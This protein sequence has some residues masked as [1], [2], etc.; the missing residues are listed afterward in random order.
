MKL[1]TRDQKQAVYTNSQS[2]SAYLRVRKLFPLLAT[3]AIVLIAAGLSSCSGYTTAPSVSG[4]GGGGGNPGDPGAGVL[5]ASSMNVGFGSVA[6]GSTGMQSVTVTNTGTSPVSISAAAITGAAFT[7]VGGNPASSVPVGQSITVQIQFAPTTTGAVTGTLTVTSDASNTPLAISL[8][9][10]GMQTVLTISPASLNFSN[11]PVG[12]TSTQTVTLG[13][14]GNSDLKINLATLTGTGFGMSGLSLPKTITAGQNLS[15]S[16]QF[17]PTSTTGST[18][19]IVFTD[20]APGPPQTLTMTGS[21][22]ATGSSLGAN[23]GSFNFN[24]VAVS[25][26]SSQTFTLTNS[27]NATITINQIVTTGPGFSASGLTVGQTI[28][29]GATATLTGTFAPTTKGAASGNIAITSTATNSTLNIPLSGTGTQGTLTAT[30]GSIPFGS[31]PVGAS[32]SVPV[33]LSNTGTSAVSITGHS[34]TGTGFTLTGWA[35]PGS[36][37]PGQTTSFTV[38]FAPT[39]GIAAS[40]SV[41]ITSNAPG[42]PL[43][44]GLTGT[45]TTTQAQMTISPATLPFNNVNVGGS[46]AQNVTLTNTGNT[47]LNI[48][49]ASITGT[50]YTMNL[51]APK[52]IAAGA[53]SILTVTFTPTSAGSFSGSVSISSNAPGSPATI[54]LTGTGIQP[55]IAASPTSVAF[56][57]VVVG[58]GNSQP[59]TL[60]NNGNGTLKFTNI[61]VTG[62]GMTITGLTTATTIA[63]GGNLTFN[64]VF[65]PT[66]TTTINGTIKLTTNGT[67][68]PLTI[69]LGGAGVTATRILSASPTSLSFGTVSVNN[70]SQLLATLTNNGNSNVTVS[71]V[72][73]TGAG[74]SASGV[75]NGMMLTPGQSATLTVTFAPVTPGAVNGARVSIASNATGSPTIITLSGTGQAVSGRSVALNWNA[76]PT[77]GINGYNVFR[78]TTSGGYGT[79][80]L[81]SSPIS[82]LTFTDSS[83]SSG[84]TYF[85]VVM[86]VNSAGNSPP[87]NEVPV[88]IP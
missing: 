4:T 69:S 15:F 73:V 23:P 9:G 8:N 54:A 28:A 27:G 64:A 31:I 51:T 12:T 24:S 79:T 2:A 74:F 87:S 65:T 45:G 5:S 17:S 71:A 26:S 41:S 1:R 86:A 36:L 42:S 58:N 43:I 48:T 37:N 84:Q 16:V 22:V 63:A 32:A 38:T 72:T 55:Q 49:A 19:S 80:P 46:L 10:T 85:Y 60:R 52:T 82:G 44:I 53:T 88:S 81:N 78:A 14:S 62:A 47:A 6:V 21:A 66:S 61:T 33:T 13:N 59:I 11:I 7:V 70:S 75:S 76:S 18:G 30:P 35:A 3:F 68:S 56:G 57:S 50:G 67:P 34:I 20:N 77:T 29:A 25:A 40:G 83:V 39:S